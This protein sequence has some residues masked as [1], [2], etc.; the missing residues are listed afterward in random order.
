[1]SIGT[2][3][4]PL[5]RSTANVVEAQYPIVLRSDNEFAG[6]IG[7][8]E[9]FFGDLLYIGCHGA[10][11]IDVYD[12]LSLLALHEVCGSSPGIACC[13]FNPLPVV[14]LFLP[15]YNFFDF[16]SFVGL[17]R[18]TESLYLLWRCSCHKCFALLFC[19]FICLQHANAPCLHYSAVSSLGLCIP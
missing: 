4:F 5:R 3:T 13:L 1:M 8:S 14:L 2:G 7:Q 12:L 10:G 15:L 17:F 18:F 11:L 6:A 9:P 19:S 16:C